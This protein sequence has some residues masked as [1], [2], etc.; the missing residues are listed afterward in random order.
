MKMFSNGLFLV[1]VIFSLTILS[2]TKNSVNPLGGGPGGNPGG[3]QTTFAVTLSHSASLGDYLVDKDGYTLYS[4]ADDYQGVSTCT[5]PGCT[6]L[7]PYFY[8]GPITQA[9]LG[10]GL[11]IV[12]FGT[13]TINGATQSTYKGWPLYY[14]AP[15]DNGG[16][17][18]TG[19]NVREAPGQIGGDGFN[20]IWFVAKPDYTVVIADGQLTGYNGINYQGSYLPGDGKTVYFTTAN[21]MTLYT[22]IHDSAGINKFT[23]ADLGN[24]SVW[25]MFETT[26]I[27]VP[28]FLDKALFSTI[29]V[30]GHSQLT[31]KGWP[32]YEFGGD[33]GIMG[34]NKGISVPKPGIWPVPVANIPAAP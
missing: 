14:Y 25:P 29:M 6:A 2:C 34:N 20:G 5:S 28:S 21:G 10:N 4:F 24:N 7:W 8:A 16:V 18:G 19:G 17:Y 12:D 33:G 11:N 15:V 27:V 31:Y 1:V 23:H 30:F 32:L 22:F 26:S 3:T 9:D 13:V